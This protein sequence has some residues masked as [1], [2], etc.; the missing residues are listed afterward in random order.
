LRWHEW[1]TTVFAGGLDAAKYLAASPDAL[2]LL[3]FLDE[4]TEKQGTLLQAKVVLEV[5]GLKS[6]EAR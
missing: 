2:E 4:K 6:K 5:M 3:A 1:G